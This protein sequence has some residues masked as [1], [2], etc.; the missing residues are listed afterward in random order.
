MKWTKHFRS[1]SEL[2]D[3]DPDIDPAQISTR[4][5]WLTM[6][7]YHALGAVAESAHGWPY[8]GPLR[9]LGRSRRLGTDPLRQASLFTRRGSRRAR[10]RYPTPTIR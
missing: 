9:P 6:P 4:R 3:Y 8:S 10:S 2:A 1:P 7:Q 5:I